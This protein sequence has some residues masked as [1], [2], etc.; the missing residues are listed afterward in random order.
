M[1]AAFNKHAFDVNGDVTITMT[2][3]RVIFSRFP[4]VVWNWLKGK[5]W[6]NISVFDADFNQSYGWDRPG[7]PITNNG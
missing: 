5:D 4:S 1:M 6:T 2:N 7:S 3:G